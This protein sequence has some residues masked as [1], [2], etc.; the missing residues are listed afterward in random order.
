[1][2]KNTYQNFTTNFLF[3]FEKYSFARNL[4]VPSTYL[5]KKHYSFSRRLPPI[6]FTPF[7]EMASL[8]NCALF[9]Y[10]T[11]VL[12][13]HHRRAALSVWFSVS[14]SQPF[15]QHMAPVHDE[16]SSRPWVRFALHSWIGSM[17]L[18]LVAHFSLTV[19]FHAGYPTNLNYP[20]WFQSLVSSFMTLNI[21]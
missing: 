11:G 19:C 2:G 17:S 4:T 16:I 7:D 15:H 18:F 8:T 12:P 20:K 3:A 10:C 6:L 14:V 1:M 5:I 21:C 9:Y 13:L